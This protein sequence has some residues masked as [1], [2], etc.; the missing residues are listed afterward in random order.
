MN[1]RE[2][3]GALSAWTRRVGGTLR[4]QW[5]FVALLLITW[6]G[7]LAVAA[8]EGGTA[9]ARI[10][11][12]TGMVLLALAA[13]RRPASCGV[14]AA[15]L[16]VL[17]TALSRFLHVEPGPGLL[18]N[19]SAAENLAGVLLVLHAF[20]GLPWTRAVPVTA[21]L[22]AACLLAVLERSP[23]G[24]EMPLTLTLEMGF[25][26]LVLAVGT[27]MYLRGDRRPRPEHGPLVGLLRRQWPVIAALSVL[28]FGQ[29]V[30][31][32]GTATTPLGAALLLVSSAIMSVLAVFAPRGPVQ[33]AMFGA[34]NMSLTVVLALL[35][36]VRAPSYV[37]GAIPVPVLAAGMLLVAFVVRFAPVRRA[38]V[39]T[40]TL[41]A[42]AVAGAVLLPRPVHGELS[43]EILGSL[44]MGA[45]L[46]VLSVSTGMYFRARDEE[47]SRGVRAAV[48]QAQHAERMALARELHDVVAHHVTGI[49]V[50]SQAALTVAEK[51]PQAARQALERISA[52][53]TEALTAMRRL[54]GSMREA[55]TR[56][57]AE[58]DGQPTTDLRGDVEKLVERV[59]ASSGTE[60]RLHT[61][62]E[63]DIPPE[64][65]RS[66][67]RLV[68][69]ALTNAGKHASGVSEIVVV[70][71]STPE[72]LLVRVD[73]DGVPGGAP[74]AGGSGGYGLVGMR[75]RIE[76]LGGTLR[77]GPREPRGWR[78]EAGL[79]LAASDAGRGLP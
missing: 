4:G 42:S 65:G 46:L 62:L 40:T 29:V 36:D 79:P 73:D 45:V 32:D 31:F 12:L 25:L 2:L 75:E 10:P 61:E 7:E 58:V 30:S 59:T 64:V 28:L 41:A 53:G 60:V 20:R 55:D 49:V 48:A 27:G 72:E 22:V 8:Y 1:P 17:A 37:V 68:Q 77:A 43:T 63:H 21:T 70:L 3:W 9:W 35:L 76:L 44:F 50:Q 74:V 19:V 26:Q 69:E 47:R 34:L 33:A 23:S 18:S 56:A 15:S 54:V 38:A 5:V 51:N 66:A 6:S 14:L 16:L 24:P 52:S 39:A 71:R 78:V 11:V 57:D 67:L 13:P